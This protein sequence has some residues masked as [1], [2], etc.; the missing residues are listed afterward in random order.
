MPA[1]PSSPDSA[2][3]DLTDGLTVRLRAAGCVFAED[4]A[5]LLTDAARTP[6]Q[7][8]EMVD[9]RVSGEPLEHILGWTEFGGLRIEVDTG[10]FVPRRRTELLARHAVDIGRRASRPVV[11]E[12]C[13][14]AGAVSAV[15]LREL[16]AVEL[17]AVDIDPAAVRC[18]RANLAGAEVYEGDL[19]EPLP[20]SLKGRVDVLVANAP[21]VPTDAVELMP[22]EARVHEPRE[23]LDGGPDGLDVIRRVT[24]SARHWLTPGGHL[25]VES[26]P[27]QATN[28]SAVFTG[29]GL[30][31]RVVGSEELGGTV[32]IG[33]WGR[34]LRPRRRRA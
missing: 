32:V 30:T 13:C 28:V 18:A 11:V 20:G 29:G 23:A 12:L 3:A 16:D 2:N 17:H 7:L 5:R 15:V 9:R 10:V 24:A 19:Y 14:G 31:P 26:S 6:S 22:R 33:R 21:Y 27:E 1:T 34:G 4:E 25:L 8:D